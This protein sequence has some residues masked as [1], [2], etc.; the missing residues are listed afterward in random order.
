[1]P[2]LHPVPARKRQQPPPAAE[3]RSA[4]W[5]HTGELVRAPQPSGSPSR[6]AARHT[7][8]ASPALLKGRHHHSA[9]PLAHRLARAPPVPPRTRRDRR[10]RAGT[11]RRRS[12]AAR[13]AAASAIAGFG[14]PPSPACGTPP[15]PACGTGRRCRQRLRR[16]E[17]HRGPLA[18]VPSAAHH[19]R[20]PHA[21]CARCRR[22]SRRRPPTPR[23]RGSALRQRRERGADHGPP[24]R[25][26][27]RS[28]RRRGPSA[29]RAGSIGRGDYCCRRIAVCSRGGSMPQV[30]AHITGTVWKIECAVGDASRRATR[31]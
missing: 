5:P 11:P 22:P 12:P 30:E 13:P 4:R 1:M 3:P 7:E 15:S 20:P 2:E 17:A 26:R 10:R 19:A 29:R 23:A 18:D 28:R 6:E 27:R 25:A 31:S 21:R 14:T 16:G 9:S 24:H 8:A